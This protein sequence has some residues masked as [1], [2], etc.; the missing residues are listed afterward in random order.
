MLSALISAA[1]LASGSAVTMASVQNKLHENNVHKFNAM[2]VANKVAAPAG[3][4]ID[5]Q[6]LKP[7]WAKIFASTYQATDTCTA[8]T[9]AMMY[10][11]QQYN[12]CLEDVNGGFQITEL[13]G[14]VMD[15][16]N[17]TT[18]WFD[19]D[20]CTGNAGYVSQG[21]APA[22]CD[23]ASADNLGNGMYQLSYIEST[24]SKYSPSGFGQQEFNSQ[25]DC[26]A[27]DAS[28]VISASQFFFD[29][30]YMFGQ[31]Y[32]VE[33]HSCTDA[34]ASNMSDCSNKLPDMPFA[35]DDFYSDDA[36]CSEGYSDDYSPVSYQSV[37]CSSKKSSAS[38]LA[39]PSVLAMIAATA[40]A[41]VAMM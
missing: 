11:Y 28:T 4:K 26:I 23:T 9:E 29:T 30:C 3:L 31:D 19:N 39:T 20:A 22:T 16:Y 35:N 14:P 17:M 21:L 38:S 15:M 13:H 6:S 40:A 34:H 27:N 18:T 5:A 8:D 25:D 10:M 37:Y 41:F 7:M 36:G 24:S 32:Y 12:T 2:K 1:L 33:V